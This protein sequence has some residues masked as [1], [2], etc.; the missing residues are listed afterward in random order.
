[1]IA[2]D[3]QTQ[4]HASMLTMDP[5]FTHGTAIRPQTILLSS[6]KD[7][8]PD[9]Q[10]A[11]QTVDLMKNKVFLCLA[12]TLIVMAILN[13]S[14]SMWVIKMLQLG[15]VGNA[16]ASISVIHSFITSPLS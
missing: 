4:Q 11:F 1:M 10:K 2:T 15:N 13:L 9:K 12:G 3:H 6:A 8:S 14:V 16:R 5:G 7:L